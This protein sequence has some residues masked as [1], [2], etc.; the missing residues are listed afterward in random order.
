MGFRAVEGRAVEGRLDDFFIGQWYV[1]STA[2]LAQ[3]AFVEL[4]LLMCDIPPFA[5]FAQSVTLH[6]L[7]E[8][9][10]WRA[11]VFDR[12]FVGGIHFHWI[13]TATQQ[14]TNL[15]IGH[16]I[17]HLK[18]LRVLAK[19]MFSGVAPRLHRVFLIVAVNRFFHSFE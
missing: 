9:H 14:L 7:R 2:K 1:E 5:G 4:F 3:L 13:V 16:V 17:D 11:F 10:G 6:R 19:K 8:N 15:V 12:R 18:Q